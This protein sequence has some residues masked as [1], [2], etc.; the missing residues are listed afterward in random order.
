MLGARFPDLHEFSATIFIFG[1]L[2]TPIVWRADYMPV[3]TWRGFFARLNPAFH[4]IEFVRAPL[5]GEAVETPTLYVMG[6]MTAAGLF[7]AYFVSLPEVWSMVRAAPA[8]HWGAFGFMVVAT[9]L[10]Y[11]NYAWFREQLCI[12]ICPYGRLQ[13]A[14]I[15]DH[16]LVIGYDAK[17]GEPR[18]KGRPRGRGHG[19]LLQEDRG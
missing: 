11:F 16:S 15:D 13:S 18:S 2:L 10:V 4:L 19:P 3:D 1:F 17:R 9:G 14:L 12:V 7:L 8:E 5:L 6:G